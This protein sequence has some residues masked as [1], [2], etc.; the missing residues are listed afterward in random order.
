[1]KLSVASFLGITRKL[2]SGLKAP[3]S[4]HESALADRYAA[5][6]HEVA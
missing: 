5:H 4:T 6:G 1:L 2:P 3:L